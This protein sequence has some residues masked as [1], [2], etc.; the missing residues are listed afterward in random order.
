MTENS[1]MNPY[2][3]EIIK[4]SLTAIGDEMFSAL[5]RTSMSPIIYETLD[6]S[7]GVTDRA[8]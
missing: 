1:K 8:G 4:S 6:Y 3:L 2:T 7:V 5:Q